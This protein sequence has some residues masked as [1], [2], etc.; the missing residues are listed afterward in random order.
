[1]KCEKSTLNRL[2]QFVSDQ[3]ATSSAIGKGG[4]VPET[5]RFSVIVIVSDDL[6][7]THYRASRD[8]YLEPGVS[9]S[10]DKL[11]L[12]KFY[13]ENVEMARD[14]ESVFMTLSALKYAGLRVRISTR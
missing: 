12:H 5:V 10:I 9:V 11:L 2:N 8:H 1:M 4:T 3:V 13:A 6:K 14:S 7:Y